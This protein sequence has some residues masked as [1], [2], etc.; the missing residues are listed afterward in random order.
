MPDPTLLHTRLALFAVALAGIAL[1][2]FP[3]AARGQVS[4]VPRTLQFGIA[5]GASLP[6][7]DLSND[8]N[9]GFN[10]TWPIGFYPRK[11]PVG[12]RVDLAYNSFGEKGN[13][14]FLPPGFLRFI[15]A[16]GNLVYRISSGA[17]APYL[18]GGAGVYNTQSDLPDFVFAPSNR[19]G[20]N[21]GGG[22]NVPLSALDVFLEARYNQIK[23]GNGSLKMIPITFGLMY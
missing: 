5:A 12:I 16:T 7:S 19:F 23:V 9:P 18:I 4:R 3:V 2:T 6:I 1:V 20:W 22:I 14:S 15:S 10:F 8:A 21:V 17:I 13:A 11:L